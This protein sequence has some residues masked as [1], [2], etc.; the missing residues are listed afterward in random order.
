MCWSHDSTDRGR[1]GDP[2]EIERTVLRG[3]DKTA[4]FFSRSSP[5]ASYLWLKYMPKEPSIVFQTSPLA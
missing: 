2:T 5:A 3:Y 4:L 1:G